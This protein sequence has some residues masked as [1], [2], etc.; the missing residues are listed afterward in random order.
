LFLLTYPLVEGRDAGWAAWTF[1]CMILAIPV[2][3]LFGLYEYRLTKT[4]G[5]PLLPLSL[6]KE[7]SFDLGMITVLVLYSGNVALFFVIALYLQIGLGF[8]ALAAGLTFVP[9]SLS[10][11]LSALVSPRLVPWLGAWVV[12]G[13]AIIML[14]GEVW[15]LLTVQ[16]AG[17]IVQG[18]QLLL[19]F[20]VMGIGQGTVLAPLIPMILSGIQTQY[21]GAASG[22]L[23]TTMQIA[24]ALGIAVIGIIFF[25]F[26]GKASPA[27]PL[28]LAHTYGHAFVASL[29]AIIVLA[30]VTLICILLLSSAERVKRNDR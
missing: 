12:R 3:M 21:A 23:T 20:L 13:G 19:P 7:R 1:I 17:M 4:G 15:T 9:I 30:A 2:L 11:A 29:V 24:G 25:G 8:S 26:L 5:E 10:F 14:V 6:F 27:Q 22:V 16:Q 18:Q 28:Q